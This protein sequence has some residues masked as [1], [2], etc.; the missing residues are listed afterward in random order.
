MTTKTLK[1]VLKNAERLCS[2]NKHNKSARHVQIHKQ[3]KLSLQKQLHCNNT[4]KT[5][6][7]TSNI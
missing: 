3:H 1:D 5:G 2:C 6:D 4:G 7:K